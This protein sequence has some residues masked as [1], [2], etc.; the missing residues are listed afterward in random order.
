MPFRPTC[1]VV[2]PT[3]QGLLSDS[4]EDRELGSRANVGLARSRTSFCQ[5][6]AT[7]TP[8]EIDQLRYALRERQSNPD[9]HETRDTICCYF[10]AR[11]LP[12]Q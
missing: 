8:I 4:F 12:G 11:R 1:T 6:A 2:V 7:A 10:F 5:Q 9:A 3:D